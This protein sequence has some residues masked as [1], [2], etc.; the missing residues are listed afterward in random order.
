MRFSTLLL[1]DISTLYCAIPLPCYMRFYFSQL[2][3]TIAAQHPTASYSAL[4]PHFFTSLFHCK[5]IHFLA[6][7][8][9]S[10]TSQ[11]ISIPLLGFTRLHFSIASHHLTVQCFALQYFTLATL[12]TSLLV[13]AVHYLHT[14]I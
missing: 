6:V 11:H 10:V 7:R 5:T 14:T 9:L 3:F 13:M 4:A 1:L 12:Y 8:S 2:N